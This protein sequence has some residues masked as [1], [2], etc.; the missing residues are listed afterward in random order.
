MLPTIL[1]TR[2]ARWQP[3][4]ALVRAWD[5][6]AMS[7]VGVRIGN[8]VVDATIQHG[9]ANWPCDHWLQGRVIVDEQPVFATDDATAQRAYDRLFARVGQTYDWLEI[10]GFP[11]LRD[12]GDPERPVCS[13][14]AYDYLT[15]ACGLRIPGRQGRIGPRLLHTAH[16]AYNLGL[17]Y[18]PQP[19]SH[20]GLMP[21][22]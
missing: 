13:R 2:A 12:M 3:L 6:G 1:Y 4:D 21:A 10:L 5:A 11:L 20:H 9:V 15:D 18:G 22:L 7:H 8:I 17:L 19:R 14:L 16:H